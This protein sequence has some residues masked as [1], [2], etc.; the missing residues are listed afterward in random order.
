MFWKNRC[1]IGLSSRNLKQA[2]IEKGLTETILAYDGIAIIVNKE[3][4]ISNL[5]LETLEKIFTGGY[6]KLEKKLMIPKKKLNQSA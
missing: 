5:Q 3:N 4:P 2:E 1:D 6:Y